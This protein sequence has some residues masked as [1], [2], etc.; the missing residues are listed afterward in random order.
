MCAFQILPFQLKENL[1][2]GFLKDTVIMLLDAFVLLNKN[3]FS[4]LKPNFLIILIEALFFL[5]DISISHLY[6]SL[7]TIGILYV[8]FSN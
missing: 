5:A 1:F 4:N 2:L 8:C 3:L 6:T 7:A